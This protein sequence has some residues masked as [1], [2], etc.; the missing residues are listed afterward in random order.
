MKTIKLVIAAALFAG[1]TVL[2]F[3]GPGPQFW[4]QQTRDAQARQAKSVV[5]TK[6]EAAPA[7]VAATCATC[8]TCA[9]CARKA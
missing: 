7:V 2:S 8:A 1:L 5:P 4:A 6:V 3:A 9:C